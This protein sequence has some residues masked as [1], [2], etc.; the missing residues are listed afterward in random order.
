MSAPNAEPS[1]TFLGR[2]GRA[3]RSSAPSRPLSVRLAPEE[4]ARVKTAAEAN[5]QSVSTFLR[6]AFLT[7]AEDTLDPIS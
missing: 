1:I 3:T 5:H 4:L 2:R 7:A 6:D